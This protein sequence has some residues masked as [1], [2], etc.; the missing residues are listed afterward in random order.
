MHEQLPSMGAG[1]GAA[2]VAADRF[3]HASDLSRV[4]KAN[5][6][7]YVPHVSTHGGAWLHTKDASKLS[8][9][10]EIQATIAETN[11]NPNNKLKLRDASIV[12]AS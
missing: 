7:P 6:G 1:R 9:R 5:L 10:A 3:G 8:V 2:V 4:A 12:L 11:A